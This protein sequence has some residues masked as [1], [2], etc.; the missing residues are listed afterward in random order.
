MNKTV[1]ALAQ[2]RM[3]RAGWNE[4]GHGMPLGVIPAPRPPQSSSPSDRVPLPSERLPHHPAKRGLRSEG[5]AHLAS[6]RG[7]TV[8]PVTSR[9]LHA[10]RGLSNA[11]DEAYAPIIAQLLRHPRP[12][13]RRMAATYLSS[14]PHPEARRHLTG[15]ALDPTED[16]RVRIAAFSA[17]LAWPAHASEPVHASADDSHRHG[18]AVRRLARATDAQLVSSHGVGATSAAVRHLAHSTPP[19]ASLQVCVAQCPTIERSAVAASNKHG[20]VARCEAHRDRVAALDL[21]AMTLV[22]RCVEDTGDDDADFASVPRHMLRVLTEDHGHDRHAHTVEAAHAR[23]LAQS[24]R[25]LTDNAA[26]IAAKHG[27]EVR[28]ETQFLKDWVLGFG[29][30]GIIGAYAGAYMASTAAGSVSGL[31]GVRVSPPRGR[32]RSISR[33]NTLVGLF[34]FG[35]VCVHVHGACW[36]RGCSLAKLPSCR[37]WTYSQRRT[38]AWWA[39][40]WWAPC[41]VGLQTLRASG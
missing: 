35:L 33:T 41:G 20:C 36:A 25:P 30:P 29:K 40:V 39:W 38:W 5:A 19:E 34:A 32:T 22:D 4:D 27:A 21:L 11:G 28:F 16:P 10:V 31:H 37:R 15:S 18:S 8:H 9:L 6:L 26:K 14:L 1:A 7:A 17:L 12:R 2:R 23:Y 24:R 13:L 3:V